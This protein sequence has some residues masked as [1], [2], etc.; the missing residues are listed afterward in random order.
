M[1]V[2]PVINAYAAVAI[3][4]F[5]S[6]GAFALQTRRTA[7]MQREHELDEAIALLQMHTEEMRK[8]D[9]DRLPQSLLQL[10]CALSRVLHDPKTLSMTVQVM[11]RRPV[12]PV[13]MTAETHATLDAI[14]RDFNHLQV[15]HPEMAASFIKA[16]FTCIL[17]F[18]KRHPE[19]AG[20]FSLG[21]PQV[22]SSPVQEAQRIVRAVERTAPWDFGR[23]GAIPV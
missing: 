14:Q 11:K 2:A 18:E 17:S 10:L 20:Q 8:L 23:T 22:V 6:M 15:Q 1:S 13:A 21:L 7:F 12:A 19:C 9:D 5:L 4:L 3:A 16:V